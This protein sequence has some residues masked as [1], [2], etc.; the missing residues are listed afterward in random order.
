M[1]RLCREDLSRQIS[2]AATRRPCLTN[3]AQALHPRP[4]EQLRTQDAYTVQ[5]PRASQAA[6]ASRI[7]TWVRAL[8]SD[9]RLQ[10]IPGWCSRIHVGC[11]SMICLKHTCPSGT[12][13]CLISTRQ[14]VRHLL[15]AAQR[16][17]DCLHFQT[18]ITRL[19]PR[20]NDKAKP[21]AHLTPLRTTRD[22]TY[23]LGHQ[24]RDLTNLLA[25]NSLHSYNDI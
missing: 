11:R 13:R 10:F 16:V 23:T 1:R 21:P 8:G 22:S 6:R 15:Q 4:R 19:M 24:R 9:M 2:N 25:D 20:S 17:E 3:P 14:C 18:Y 5:N 12:L 7:H